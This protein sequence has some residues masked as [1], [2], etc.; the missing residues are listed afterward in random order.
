MVAA[1]KGSGARRIL[2]LGCGEGR[3]LAT[4]LKETTA[5]E[6]VGMDVSHTALVRARERLRIDRLPP[7]QAARLTLFQDRWPTATPGWTGSTRRRLWR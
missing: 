2:D 6:L 1:L 5:P 3:L 7:L 4:L